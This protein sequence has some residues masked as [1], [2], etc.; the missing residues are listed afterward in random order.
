MSAHIGETGAASLIVGHGS[1]DDRPKSGRMVMVLEMCKLMNEHVVNQGNR[2]LHRCPVDIHDATRRTG[3]PSV[4]EPT[5]RKLGYRY[6]EALCPRGSAFRQPGLPMAAIPVD[7]IVGSKA[8]PVTPNLKPAMHQLHWRRRGF[9]KPESVAPTEV[10]ET[11]PSGESLRWPV[12]NRGGPVLELGVDPTT[13]ALDQLRQLVSG[14]A[15]WDRRSDARVTLDGQS[16]A[17]PLG[18]DND[19]DVKA[20]D[21]HRP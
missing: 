1:L 3:S 20:A 9:D 2:Q 14:K 13:A 15:G 11:L 4:A 7:Q 6:A 5:D 12:G 21:V 18:G 8:P 19:I 10:R 16:H 17:P